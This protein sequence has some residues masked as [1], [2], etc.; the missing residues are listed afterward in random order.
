MAQEELSRE[1]LEGLARAAGIDL[2]TVS[3][4]TL[5]KGDLPVVWAGIRRLDDLK[6]QNELPAFVSVL[7]EGGND[8]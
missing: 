6:V 8:D 1:M 7:E 4:E 2:E 3:V 5:M